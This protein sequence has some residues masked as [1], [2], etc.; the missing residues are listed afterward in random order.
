MNTP[1]SSPPRPPA[2]APG[3]PHR[4]RRNATQIEEDTHSY[5]QR[6]IGSAKVQNILTGVGLR[7]TELDKNLKDDDE[8]LRSLKLLF[9]GKLWVLVNHMNGI[10]VDE[11]YNNV[12]LLVEFLL[13][14]SLTF[15]QLSTVRP[16]IRPLETGRMTSSTPG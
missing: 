4:R 7:G 5:L 14:G 6:L 1:P 11:L 13:N 3:A 15:V 2:A 9:E 10:G 16:P 12:P 8:P